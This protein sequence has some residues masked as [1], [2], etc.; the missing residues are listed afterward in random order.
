MSLSRRFIVLMFALSL[1]AFSMMS[2]VGQAEGNA[3]SSLV[4]MDTP[5]MSMD[6]PDPQDNDPLPAPSSTPPARPPPSNAPGLFA[7]VADL[8]PSP[9]GPPPRQA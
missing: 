4:A 2:A 5:L 7:H 9:L 1:G 8:L 3:A 6:S